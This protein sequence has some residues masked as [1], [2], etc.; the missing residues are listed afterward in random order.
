MRNM[1]FTLIE[2][3]RYYPKC[4]QYLIYKAE[5]KLKFKGKKY[6]NLYC[7]EAGMVQC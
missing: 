7:G 4:N 2:A 6:T 5:I 3:K 1:H